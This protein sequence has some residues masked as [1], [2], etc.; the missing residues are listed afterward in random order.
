MQAVYTV[1][2]KF[3]NCWQDCDTFIFGNVC[4]L[5]WSLNVLDKLLRKNKISLKAGNFIARKKPGQRHWLV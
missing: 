2:T 4:S 3:T 1:K 5:M